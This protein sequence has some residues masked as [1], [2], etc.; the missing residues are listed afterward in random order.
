M[1]LVSNQ[2]N[3]MAKIYI[4]LGITSGDWVNCMVL[5]FANDFCN[6]VI[7][8][9][10]VRVKVESKQKNSIRALCLKDEKH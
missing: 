1:Q 5:L 7:S 3:G 6:E 4:Q 2:G 10:I 9:K 8:E